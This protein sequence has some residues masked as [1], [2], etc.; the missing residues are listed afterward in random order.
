MKSFGFASRISRRLI[1][2]VSGL[3]VAAGI[4]AAVTSA[5]LSKHAI[6][7]RNAAALRASASVDGTM[8]TAAPSAPFAS[9]ACDAGTQVRTSTGPVCGIDVNGDRE[10][11]GIPYAAPPVGALRWQS[12]QPH[13]PW[14]TTLQA[15]AFGSECAQGIQL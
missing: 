5:S 3:L 4:A 9:T 12:P 1:V 14:T 15:N 10:W 2:I 7:A 6:S 8:S 11:L 13:A